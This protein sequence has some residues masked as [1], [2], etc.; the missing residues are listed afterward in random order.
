MQ[1]RLDQCYNVSV[2]HLLYTNE[3]EPLP[4]GPLDVFCVVS[5]C[6]GTFV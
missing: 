4:E 3:F 1:L 6:N 5:H 2:L